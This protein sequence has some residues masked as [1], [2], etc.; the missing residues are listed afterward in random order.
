LLVAA[1]RLSP[2]PHLL[3][4]AGG[5]SPDSVLAE[6]SR[7]FFAPETLIDDTFF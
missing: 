5:R 6:P 1:A 7:G 4:S 2:D 3:T